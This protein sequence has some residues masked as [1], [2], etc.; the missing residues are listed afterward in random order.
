MHNQWI[1]AV[2]PVIDESESLP[3]LT[4]WIERLMYEQL[5]HEVIPMLTMAAINT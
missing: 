2:I 4:A 5:P 1:F 3:E